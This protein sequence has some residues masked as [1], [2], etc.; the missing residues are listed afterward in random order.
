MS[1]SYRLGINEP[2]ADIGLYV[3]FPGMSLERIFT[4]LYKMLDDCDDVTDFK[5]DS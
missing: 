4:T 2:D 1:G 5:P 3:S